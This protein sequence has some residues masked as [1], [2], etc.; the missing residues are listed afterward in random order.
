MTPIRPAAAL[1]AILLTLA[2]ARAE[3][4]PTGSPVLDAAVDRLEADF[5]NA[6]AM[7]SLEETVATVAANLPGLATAEPAVLDDAVAF[8]LASLGASHTARYTSDTVEYYEL[9]DVFRY[10]VRDRLRALYPAGEVIYAGIGAATVPIDGV[11]FLTDVYDGGPAARAGLLSGDEVVAVDGAP[12]TGLA[13]FADKAGATVKVSVRRA[14]GTAPFDVEVAVEWL[15]PSPL[16]LD[17]IR[18]SAR[19]VERDG[20]RLGYLRLWSWTER[21]TR[22]VVEAALAG[23]L[24]DADGL[25][26]DLRSRWGGAPAD[27]ADSFIGGGPDMTMTFRN[28]TTDLVHARWRKAIVAIVDRGTRSGMEI[29]AHAL[30]AG[31]V[32][33][34]GETTAGA[35]LAGRGFLLPDDSL[36]I[37]AVADVSVDGQRLEGVGVAPDIAVPFDIRFAAGADPQLDAAAAE[38]VRSLT[39]TAGP[40]S[41]ATP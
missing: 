14:P 39:V 26:L 22:D 16:F 38:L 40:P 29:L 15:K 4:P 41:T 21:E 11:P 17:A 36:L 9:L 28:G 18:D 27:A 8:V 25:I 2:P 1:A 20:F 33:L 35:V 37:V 13:A 10:G 3:A 24:A 34:V 23:P 7:P 19:I 12:F 32:R 6:A 30:K 5:Y 31:G